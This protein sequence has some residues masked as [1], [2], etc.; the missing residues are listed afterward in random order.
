M[1][2]DPDRLRRAFNPPSEHYDVR[3]T[4]AF[5]LTLAHRAFRQYVAAD[6]L[7]LGLHEG[8]D[9]LL[10]ELARMEGRATSRELASSLG[11]TPGTLSTVLRRSE[12][13]GLLLR[14]RDGCDSRVWR[15]SLTAEGRA[16]AYGGAALWRSADEELGRAMSQ[17]DR[18][19][20]RVLAREAASAWGDARSEALAEPEAIGR[21]GGRG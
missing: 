1:G 18:S 13:D 20:L 2:W 17:A 16:R 14:E 10:V 12:V 3:G 6:R 15:L 5:A 7:E 11:V 4:V 8:R 19:W 21:E 9:L